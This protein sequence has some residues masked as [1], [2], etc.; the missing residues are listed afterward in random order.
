MVNGVHTII[1]AKDAAKARAFFKDVLGYPSVDAGR[2]WLIFALPPGEIA[3]H[4]SHFG[5]G[6]N[7]KHELYLMCDDIAKTVAELKEKGV[8]FKGE[9][10]DRGWGILTTLKI[11]GGGTMGLYQ[12]KH[13]VAA[14]LK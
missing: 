9:P 10:K 3:A 12:P 2:G 6:R 14:K 8:E 7:G 11:P 4:P 1:Y 13:P 5:G